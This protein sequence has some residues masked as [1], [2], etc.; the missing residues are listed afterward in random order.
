MFG[1]VTPQ[2]VGD[3]YEAWVAAN[4]SGRN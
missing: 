3:R 1:N 4:D 2:E